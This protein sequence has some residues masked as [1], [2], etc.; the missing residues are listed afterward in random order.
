MHAGVRDHGCDR[1]RRRGCCIGGGF[2]LV[3]V[4]GAVRRGGQRLQ[5]LADRAGQRMGVGL[6]AI[7]GRRTQARHAGPGEDEGRRRRFVIR[8]RVRFRTLGQRVGRRA[9]QHAGRRFAG[10]AAV[11]VL[12][13]VVQLRL[14]RQL[15]HRAHAD[16]R[17][18][19]H[20]HAQRALLV[21]AVQRLGRAVEQ[22]QCIGVALGGDGLQRHAL[23]RPVRADLLAQPVIGGALLRGRPVARQQ[24]GD[25]QPHGLAAGLRGEAGGGLRG[26][27]VD[28]VAAQRQRAQAFV[29]PLQ[30]G[31]ALHQLVAQILDVEPFHRG[32]EDRRADPL[33]IRH[34]RLRVGLRGLDQ[35]VDV[36]AGG[37]AEGAAEQRGAPVAGGV[38]RVGCRCGAV[39]G[40]R[41]GGRR[42]FP[43]RR[44]IGAGAV[45]RTPD[46]PV[47]D[48][49]AQRQQEQAGDDVGGGRHAV[50]GLPPRDGGH[51]HHG[52]HR[53]Q[54][55][56]GAEQ[57]FCEHGA[58][59][60]C[61]RWCPGWPGGWRRRPSCRHG[62]RPAGHR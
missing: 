47:A 8:G 36:G 37:R 51:P 62:A 61:C 12:V 33:H 50:G 23:G 44:D 29:R 53:Q 24:G 10:Q 38:L 9:Q 60:R 58:A 49:H 52:E 14:L 17:I 46:D 25:D 5:H 32:R 11:L 55:Q 42:E 34:V 16:Q 40:H 21:R 28:H 15:F 31:M 20:Y 41:R 22:E 56:S 59:V 7:G 6:A 18:G 39:R 1:G 4:V 43:S 19:H 3:A 54:R 48:H 35:R 13:G 27:F 45:Q 2:G 57:S 26:Q 30:P